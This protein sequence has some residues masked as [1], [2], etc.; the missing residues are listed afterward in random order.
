MNKRT[1][2]SLKSGLPNAIQ[3]IAHQGLSR[4]DSRCHDL[5]LERPRQAISQD[6]QVDHAEFLFE[7]FSLIHTD[8]ICL[9][10]D[11]IDQFWIDSYHPE[12]YL[13]R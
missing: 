8:H 4:A 1:W 9:V 10:S 5:V 7:C 2:Q 12:K 13:R 6:C 11:R 3:I